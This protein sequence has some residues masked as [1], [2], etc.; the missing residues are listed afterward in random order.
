MLMWVVWATVMAVVASEC[1]PNWSGSDCSIY[2][3]FADPS[4]SYVGTVGTTK[5]KYYR[6]EIQGLSVKQS[7]WFLITNF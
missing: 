1:E 3:L 5:W 2:S 4:V 6:A 7:F